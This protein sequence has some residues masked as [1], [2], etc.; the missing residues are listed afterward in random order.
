MNRNKPIAFGKIHNGVQ[1]ALRDKRKELRSR[2]EDQVNYRN[3]FF[4]SKE[5]I[6]LNTLEIKLMDQLSSEKIKELKREIEE[7]EK[8]QAENIKNGMDAPWE[9]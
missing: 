2:E 3:S 8:K 7:L 5:I 9:K 1:V 4:E 6:C